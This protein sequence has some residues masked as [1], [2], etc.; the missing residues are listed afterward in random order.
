M[1]DFEETIGLEKLLN[2]ALKNGAS[3]ADVRFQSYESELISVENKTLDSYSARKLSGFGI[4]VL[5]NG[6]VGFASS[7]NLSP[8]S[9][10][11]TLE[12][13]VKAAKAVKNLNASLAEV[14]INKTDVNST[15]KIDPFNVPPEEK[16]SIALDANK[17]AW[18][19]DRIKNTSTR[20]G[21]TKDYRWFASSDGSMNN[22]SNDNGGSYARERC[23]SQRAHGVGSRL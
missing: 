6:G 3:Y 22:R 11:K 21:M 10:K 19:D 4:R 7:S 8:A 18:N 23:P 2:R 13:A 12:D 15:A 14:K 16:V 1:K 20:L 5:V 17:A 9:T